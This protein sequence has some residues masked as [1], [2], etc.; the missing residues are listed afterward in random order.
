MFGLPVTLFPLL[1]LWTRRRSATPDRPCPRAQWSMPGDEA[2]TVPRPV[3]SET[4]RER[5][6]VAGLG[7]IL[8]GVLRSQLQ[9][10]CT[11]KSFSRQGA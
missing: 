6:S 10:R 4:L 1:S 11:P 5:R 8:S 2:P 9:G 3:L 7:S